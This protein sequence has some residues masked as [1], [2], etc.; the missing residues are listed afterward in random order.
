MRVRLLHSRI[1]LRPVQRAKRASGAWTGLRPILQTLAFLLLAACSRPAPLPIMGQVPVFDLVAQDGQPF[2]SRSLDGRIWVA[3]FIFTHCDGPCPMMSRH[4]RN[5]QTQ[6][7]SVRLVSF[8]VDPARDTPAE[9]A[10]YAKH[11]TAQPSRW[12]FLTGDAA[13]LNDLALHTFKLNSV[14]GSLTHSTRFVLVDGRR[15]IR[16]Y[17]ISSE[18]G[19]LTKLMHDIRQLERE[20]S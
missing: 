2:D 1:G 15:N 8:T 13:R 14:D 7:A 18:D 5:I 16:G 3:D 9:L 17:Y 4:M 10:A 11:F 20:P 19:F 6:S 12:S